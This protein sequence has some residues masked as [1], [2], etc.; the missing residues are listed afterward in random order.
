MGKNL[1][2]QSQLSISFFWCV[3][4]NMFYPLHYSTAD[5]RSIFTHLLLGAV[6]PQHII[7]WK[8]VHYLR[9]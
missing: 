2:N 7:T 3:Y 4:V 5:L 1:M 8:Q 9:D 6:S